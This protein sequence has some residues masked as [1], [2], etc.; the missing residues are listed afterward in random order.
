MFASISKSY[1]VDLT[2]WARL[3]FSAFDAVEE[4]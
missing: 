3:T 4:F 1:Q 2:P